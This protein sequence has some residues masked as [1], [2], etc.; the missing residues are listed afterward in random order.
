M[1]HAAEQGQIACSREGGNG[2]DTSRESDC[3]IIG[4]L[5]GRHEGLSSPA[6][7]P[8]APGLA[9]DAI[10]RESGGLVQQY[11]GAKEAAAALNMTAKS[12]WLYIRNKK[13]TRQGYLLSYSKN[14][15][16]EGEEWRVCIEDSDYMVSSHGR[17]RRKHRSRCL[18]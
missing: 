5:E 13:V 17:V 8:G 6:R 9:I 4:S 11:S 7:R 3:S 14:P 1:V 12:V 2:T 15:D 18:R 10:C 16:I